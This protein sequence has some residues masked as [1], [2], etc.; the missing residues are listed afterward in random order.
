MTITLDKV[1]DEYRVVM[2]YP[3][4]MKLPDVKLT[5]T[6]YAKMSYWL[7]KESDKHF[8]GEKT[9][10]PEELFRKIG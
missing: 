3:R 10:T 1:G 6:N 2:A 4:K 9:K 7:K 8:E 5:F